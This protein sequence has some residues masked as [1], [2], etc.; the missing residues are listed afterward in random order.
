M[1]Q[2]PEVPEVII[3]EKNRLMKQQILEKYLNKQE[4]NSELENNQEIEETGNIGITDEEMKEINEIIS[5]IVDEKVELIEEIVSEIPGNVEF[6]EENTSLESATSTYRKDLYEV[7]SKEKIDEFLTSKQY[8]PSQ[9]FYKL[10]GLY[11]VGNN[12]NVENLYDYV[13][14]KTQIDPR[15][16]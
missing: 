8:H 6:I 16:F 3:Q 1:I 11:W 4:N 2:E 10:T 14:I 12:E 5:N 13:K 7:Y 15:D 9:V